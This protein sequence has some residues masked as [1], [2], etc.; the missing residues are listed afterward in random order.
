M[1]RLSTFLFLALAL[2]AWSADTTK[3]ACPAADG[4]SCVASPEDQKQA[5]KAFTRGV[6]LRDNDQT[7]EAFDEF[8]HASRLVPDNVEYATAREIVRQQ[9]VYDALQRGNG[10]MLNRQQ[11][12][13]LA[14]FRT[15]L[16]LDPKNDFALQ[17]MRDALGEESPQSSPALRLAASVDDVQLQPRPVT[18][19]FHYKGDTRGLIEA[20]ALTFNVTVFFDD[21]FQAKQA[22]VDVPGL[23]FYQAMFVAGKLGKIFWVPVSENQFLVASD[24]PENRRRFERMSLRSFYVSDATS[25]QALTELQN[26]LRAVFDIR[27]ISTQANKS[28]LT[29]RAPRD[30]VEA[31]SRFLEGLSGGPPQVMLDIQVY[32]ISTDALRDLGVTLPL[33]YTLFNL[34]NVL[35]QLQNQPNIQDLINQLFSGGGINQ[36]NS[37]AIQGL[38]AQLQNQANSIL[39]NPVATFGGG[40]TLM[41]LAIKPAKIAVNFNQSTVKSLEHLTMRA[42]QGDTSSILIGTRYPILNASFSPIFN[43]PQIAQVI[44][45]N[46]FQAAFPSFT[47]EDLGLT[48]KATPQIHATSD[49]TLKMEMH[50]R[51]LGSQTFNGIPVIAN[52]EYD[53]TI[54]LKNGETALMVGYVTRSEQR[55]LTGLPGLGQVVGLGLIASEEIDE[56]ASDELL[57]LVTPHIIQSAE[58]QNLEVWMS[59]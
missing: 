34:S 49:V 4:G 24:T 46:S 5:R 18:A 42:R 53:G 23:G 40:I 58:H 26:M 48:V 22:K 14:E 50:I 36:A 6:R 21:S 17:R 3:P 54:N 30:T 13:A 27:H 1:R 29:I 2:P 15:A 38:L 47:F 43:T 25:P 51:A 32:E 11:V 57:V 8:N 44:Q 41:G 55:S 52:R 35:S 37:Q 28:I 7:E 59:K 10:Y 16:E 12:E 9:L 19:S 20:I 45:N 39:S 31:A 33:Q 56:K